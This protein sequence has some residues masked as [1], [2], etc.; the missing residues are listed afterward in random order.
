MTYVV[1]NPCPGLLET[2]TKILHLEWERPVT[3]LI[4]SGH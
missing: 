1:G 2:G 4:G 3:N